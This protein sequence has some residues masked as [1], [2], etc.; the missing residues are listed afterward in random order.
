MEKNMETGVRCAN[1]Q[2]VPRLLQV[3]NE[4]ILFVLVLDSHCF[5]AFDLR[6]SQHLRTDMI[7]MQCRLERSPNRRS[8]FRGS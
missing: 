3:V 1:W 4:L 7:G 6:L 2:P 8:H 5:D